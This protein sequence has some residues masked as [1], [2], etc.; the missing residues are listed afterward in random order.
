VEV[1]ESERDQLDALKKWWQH[2][3]KAI[4]IG[5]ILGLGSLIGWQQWQASTQAARESASLEYDVLL[6]DLENHN[7]QGVKD[8]GA[9]I[10]NKFQGTPYAA[11]TAL[12]VAKVNVEEGDLAA[13]RTYLQMVIDQKDQPQ[14]QHVARLRLAQ[15]LLAQDQ[16]QQALDLVKAID[17]A[18]FASAYDEL[19]GDIHVA[20][21]NIAEAR[22]AYERAIAAMDAAVD[23]TVIKMKL[24]DLGETEVSL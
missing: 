22:S 9:N 13:A 4:I 1:Y 11:L 12:A 6:A 21:G 16:A 15:L 20:L 7:Y 24:D 23:Q 19:K 2:N 18:G 14:L 8:R 3:S 17:A 5:T 10:L